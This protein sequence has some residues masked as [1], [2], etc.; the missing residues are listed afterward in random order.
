ME[1]S[2]SMA[3]TLAFTTLSFQLWTVSIE[4]NVKPAYPNEGV[5]R[6]QKLAIRSVEGLLD[7]NL[8]FAKEVGRGYLAFQFC[9]GLNPR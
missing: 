6:A 1:S 8:C 5:F 7:V 9:F 3:S 2:S 4:G